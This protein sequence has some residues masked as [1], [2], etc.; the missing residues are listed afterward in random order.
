MLE[1]RPTVVMLLFIIKFAVLILIPS[2]TLWKSAKAVG[3]TSTWANVC[4]AA[5][6]TMSTPITAI[7]VQT[8]FD[9]LPPCVARSSYDKNLDSGSWMEAI[10]GHTPKSAYLEVQWSVWLE[11]FGDFHVRPYSLQQQPPLPE[12][13]HPMSTSYHLWPHKIFSKPIK[14]FIP[15]SA[16][17]EDRENLLIVK[18]QLMTDNWNVV[19]NSNVII[20]S[21]WATVEMKEFSVAGVVSNMCPTYQDLHVTGLI[22]RTETPS[23]VVWY[24]YSQQANDINQICTDICEDI[25]ESSYCLLYR[26]DHAQK[27]KFVPVEKFKKIYGCGTP[28]TLNMTDELKHRSFHMTDEQ[29]LPEWV[30]DVKYQPFPAYYEDLPK[31]KEFQLSLEIRQKMKKGPWRKIRTLK[32]M[33]YTCIDGEAGI[34]KDCSDVEKC[35]V[36]IENKALAMTGVKDVVMAE[37]DDTEKYAFLRDQCPE[38][39]EYFNSGV[40]ERIDKGKSFFLKECATTFNEEVVKKTNF[41]CLCWQEK[42]KLKYGEDISS[43]T[44]GTC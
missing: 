32:N 33:K 11:N 19:N 44:M 14:L 42:M 36:V 35:Q 3:G 24:M 20:E 21:S 12:N 43:H 5:A 8:L 17:E 25:L 29:E 31:A 23:K 38:R 13:M 2:F 40:T 37:K 16:Y 39:L 7:G 4:S 27:M 9:I 30:I 6:Y 41:C 22:D 34:P 1:P 28:F 10:T 15:H 18:R 26:A